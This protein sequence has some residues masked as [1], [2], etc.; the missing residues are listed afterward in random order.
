MGEKNTIIFVRKEDV[1]KKRKV[2]LGRKEYR[3]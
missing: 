2:I 1:G 3:P